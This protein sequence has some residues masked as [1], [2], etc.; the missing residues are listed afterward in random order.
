ML[1]TETLGIDS[2]NASVNAT[3]PGHAGVPPPLQQQQQHRS[4]RTCLMANATK[5]GHS[6]SMTLATE[7]QSASRHTSPPNHSI[8]S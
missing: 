2:V 3:E 6:S 7:D 1:G 5:S 4:V 8:S